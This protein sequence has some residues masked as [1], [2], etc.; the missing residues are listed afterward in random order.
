MSGHV[1]LWTLAELIF[2]FQ[3][4]FFSFSFVFFLPWPSRSSAVLKYPN[5]SELTNPNFRRKWMPRGQGHPGLATRLKYR[6]ARLGPSMHMPS[7]LSHPK[8]P[9]E[10]P[11]LDACVAASP[12]GR[13][14]N[15]F[16]RVTLAP[17]STNPAC[18]HDMCAFGLCFSRV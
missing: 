8:Y 5:F 3:S 14:F 13:N 6:T 7:M 16:A 11:A 18:S 10:P 2:D 17:H 12:N 9:V 1:E 4:L 15:N